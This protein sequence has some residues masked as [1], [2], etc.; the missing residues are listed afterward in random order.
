M[1]KHTVKGR[2]ALLSAAITVSE[3]IVRGGR[4][5]RGESNYATGGG[6]Q[7]LDTLPVRGYQTW[8]IGYNTMRTN[9]GIIS[10]ISYLWLTKISK[11]SK[12]N[13]SFA[14]D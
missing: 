4:G 11:I 3:Q 5:G 14:G 2:F 10:Y 9:S 8:D 13:F 1:K 6:E 12:W 7:L